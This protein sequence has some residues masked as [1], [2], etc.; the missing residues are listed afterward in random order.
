MKYRT[1][2]FLS[3]VVLLMYII[4]ITSKIARYIFNL[5]G[6]GCPNQICIG[7]M[8]CVPLNRAGLGLDQ[9]DSRKKLQTEGYISYITVPSFQKK[10]T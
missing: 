1:V 2:H 5:C 4:D 8:H 10:T 3:Q 7:V 9:P 6:A